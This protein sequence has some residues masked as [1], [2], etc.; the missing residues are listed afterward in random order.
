LPDGRT[1]GEVTIADGYA[2]EY[3]YDQP[4]AYRD[5]LLAAQTTAMASQAGLWSATTCAGDTATRRECANRIA[6]RHRPG[7]SASDGKP[8][9][10]RS[11]QVRRSR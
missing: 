8:E 1:F 6:N 11:V 9:R 7:G 3:T 2:H 4:Y 10:L 5:T